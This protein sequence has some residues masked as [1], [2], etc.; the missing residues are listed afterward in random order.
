MRGSVLIRA[1][2]SS[3]LTRGSFRSSSTRRSLS[4]SALLS[5]EPLPNRYSIASAPSRTTTMRFSSRLDLNA[6][7]IRS[8]SL[9]LSST[10]RTVCS[11]DD[12]IEPP[13]LTG[14]GLLRP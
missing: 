11:L 10:I 1:S 4:T 8:M 12:L 2:T 14:P 6:C 3:P 9:G 13:S 7:S 5:F